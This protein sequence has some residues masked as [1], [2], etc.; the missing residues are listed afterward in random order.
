M[1]SVERSRSN[2]DEE[3]TD[4]ISTGEKSGSSIDLVLLKY[5]EECAGRVV[6]DPKYVSL[7][8]LSP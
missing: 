5:Y 2:V 1:A 7:F 4:V 8:L 6:L 3:K